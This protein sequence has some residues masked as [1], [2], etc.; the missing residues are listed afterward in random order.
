[1]PSTQPLR[2]RWP[3]PAIGDGGGFG[4]DDGG[5]PLLASKGETRMEEEGVASSLSPVRIVRL[6][7]GG[8]EKE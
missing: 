1:M 6:G 5:E 8:G 4:D 3:R 7:D 2:W